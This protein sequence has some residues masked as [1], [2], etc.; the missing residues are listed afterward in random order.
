MRRMIN[1]VKRDV[2]AAQRV[3]QAIKLRCA[4]TPYA[5]IAAQCGYGSA[6][7]AHKAIQRELRRISV[8]N[9]DE[10]RR[11][12][13][14]MLDELQSICFEQIGE[15][16]ARKPGVLFAVDRLLAI[17]DRRSK[18]CGLNKEKDEQAVFAGVVVREAPAGY[19]GSEEQAAPNMETQGGQSE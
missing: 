15:H 13:L 11:E 9:I 7:A 5:T 16:G 18:L 4:K 6:G 2:N 8:E 1:D 19:F 14:A 3:Q 17:S 12:E 10:L